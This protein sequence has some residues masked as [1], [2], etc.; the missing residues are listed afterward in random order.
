MAQL[1]S[2]NATFCLCERGCEKISIFNHCLALY[3]KRYKKWP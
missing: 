3:R 1:N 2:H